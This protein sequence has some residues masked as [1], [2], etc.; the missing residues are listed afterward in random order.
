M[1]LKQTLTIITLTLSVSAGIAFA[2]G[3]P[4]NVKNVQA[5]MSGDEITVLWS[6]VP[7]ASSYRVYYSHRSI[8]SHQGNYDDVEQTVGAGMTFVF[9]KPPLQ[10]EKIYFGV[11][12]VDAEGNESDGFETEAFVTMPVLTSSSSSSVASEA[13]QASSQ[14]SVS[15]EVSMPIGENPTS[16]ALRMGIESVHTVSATGVLVSFTKELHPDALVNNESFLITTVSGTLLPIEK[17][18]IQGKHVLITVKPY[19]PDTEYLLSLLAPIQAI[20]G[21]NATPTEPRV[22]FQT[23]ATEDVEMPPQ[24]YGKNP[25]IL[26]DT[27]PSDP[28]RLGLSAILRKDG[29]YNVIAN[30][31]PSVDAEQYSLSTSENG[32]PYTRNSL[33]SREKTHVEYSNIAPGTFGVKVASRTNNMES[34]GIEKVI[35]LPASGLGLLGIIAIAGAEAGRRVRRRKMQ[36]V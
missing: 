8:L 22:Q 9:S 31:A 15:S 24:Q 32:N 1:Y 26:T 19:S 33:V 17:T 28:S 27:R 20:D 25:N 4:E 35:V 14:S 34:S 11:L 10:S 6:H 13:M 3:L 2:A 16:T 29:T 21:T 12:A 5:R 18:E 7:T 36:M 23:S 30:W